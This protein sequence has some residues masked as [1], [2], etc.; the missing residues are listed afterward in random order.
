VEQ[1]VDLRKK[2]PTGEDVLLHC[3]V[4][5]CLLLAMLFTLFTLCLADA[6]S[7]HVSYIF[8]T[9]FI[10]GPAPLRNSSTC[11]WSA[12]LVVLGLIFSRK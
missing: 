7:F 9:I 4:G 5:V 1:L 2:Y 11:L 8:T 3:G 12:G 10:L 6:I